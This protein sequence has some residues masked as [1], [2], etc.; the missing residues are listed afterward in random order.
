[1]QAPH[2][3]Q[4]ATPEARWQLQ[5]TDDQAH[6][7]PLAPPL[8]SPPAADA[9]PTHVKSVVVAKRR[10]QPVDDSTVRVPCLS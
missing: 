4:Q 7:T 10:E 3:P 5:D 8:A 2:L 9:P 1:M 6:L